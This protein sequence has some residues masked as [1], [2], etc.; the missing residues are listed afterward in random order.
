LLDFDRDKSTEEIDSAFMMIAL[1]EAQIAGE[2][3]EVPIG[4]V[5]VH[6]GKIIGRGHNQN[7]TLNDPTAHAEMI[8]VSAACSKVESRY[9]EQAT[10]YVTVEPCAMCAG[11]AVLARLGRLV[12]GARDPKAG[13]C[14][15]LFNILQDPRLNHTVEVISGVH[16]TEC[17]AMISNFFESIRR[18][19]KQ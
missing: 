7:K 5:V 14:G 16:E 8:A 4:A 17:A 19:Q 15:S 11:A 10:L 12:F 3:G 1:R 9:L 2:K 13:A 6:D 18:Q